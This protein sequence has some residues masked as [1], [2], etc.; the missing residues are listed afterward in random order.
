MKK[1]KVIW[2]KIADELEYK[3]Y[4]GII[5]ENS[6]FPSYSELSEQY[7]IDRSTAIKVCKYLEGNN[8]I[9]RK[10]GLGFFLKPGAKEIVR[11]IQMNKIKE[12]VAKLKQDAD[13]LDIPSN[14][15]LDMFK[16][17]WK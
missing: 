12:Q 11:D 9:Y 8:I 3:I 13:L 7:S 15:I 17:N 10:S 2:D 16:S 1:S 14:E 5:S 6:K 4:K